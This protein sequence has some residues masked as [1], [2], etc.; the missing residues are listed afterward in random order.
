MAF[1]LTTTVSRSI[2]NRGRVPTAPIP[3]P[4][5]LAR[6]GNEPPHKRRRVERRSVKECLQQQIR[7]LVSS[8]VERLP[9]EV[10][11]INALAIKVNKQDG[12]RHEVL[13]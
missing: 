8:A 1:G 2:D 11:H 9:R 3:L 13:N 10:Y 4:H 7:P 5:N 6:T 12:S